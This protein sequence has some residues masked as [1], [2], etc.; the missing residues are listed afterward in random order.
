MAQN[1]Q[2]QVDNFWKNA[3]VYCDRNETPDNKARALR[4]MYTAQQFF[5]ENGFKVIPMPQ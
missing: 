5:L 1:T 3:R 2:Q 4:N